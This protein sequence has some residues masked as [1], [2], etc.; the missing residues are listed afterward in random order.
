MATAQCPLPE[1]KWLAIPLI[2]EGI[3]VDEPIPTWRQVC[4][5]IDTN[6]KPSYVDGL[7]LRMDDVI[8]QDVWVDKDPK[9]GNGRAKKWN[10]VGDLIPNGF[11]GKLEVVVNYEEWRNTQTGSMKV[12][13]EK[14]L[15]RF[16]AGKP[17]EVV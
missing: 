6:G 1:P 13:V 2:H 10:K 7:T 14:G 3:F 9:M 16:E 15:V 11:T 8:I 12:E 4:I 5:W 17:V